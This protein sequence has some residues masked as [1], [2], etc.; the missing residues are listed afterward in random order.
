MDK[1]EVKNL[2][3]SF[4]ENNVFTDLNFMI[5]SESFTSIIINNGKTTFMNILSGIINTNSVYIDNKKITMN[6]I[7]KIGYVYANNIFTN[8]IVKDEILFGLNNIN[9]RESEILLNEVVDLFDIKEILNYNIR[10]LNS[11]EKTIVKLASAL[12]KKPEILIIDDIL[13]IFNNLEKDKIF[14]ILKKLNQKQNMTIINITSNIEE[15]LY[16]KDAIVIDKKV[17]IKGKTK[18]VLEEIKQIEQFG[19]PF[20]VDLSNKLKYYEVIDKLIL[21]KDEMVDAIWD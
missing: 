15:V 13:N 8:E 11:R 9:N 3:F 1:I 17:I 18:K 12:I 2:T 20:I 19:L 21:K 4:K 7:N 16:S 14:K 6:E 5:K 10:Y